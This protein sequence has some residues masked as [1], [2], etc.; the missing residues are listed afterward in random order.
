M[1]WEGLPKSL[2]D[3]L[4]GSSLREKHSPFAGAFF[5]GIIGLKGVH[6]MI[7]R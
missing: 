1:N 7:G 4:S 3:R 5:N 6:F 2:A